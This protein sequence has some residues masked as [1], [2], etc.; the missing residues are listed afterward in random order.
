MATSTF[1]I[2]Q[3]KV[4]CCYFCCC[5]SATQLC[6][7]LCNSMNYSMPGLPIPHHPQSLP[8]FM[9]IALVMPSSH[10][11][12]WCP[13]LLLPSIFPKTRDFSDESS[14][15]IR[16][17]KYGSFNVSPSSD[18]SGLISL[19]IDWFDLLACQGTFRSLLQHHGSKT[20][21]LWHSAF[22]TVQLSN[23]VCPLGR[24]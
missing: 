21:V 10:L 18:Y 6:L 4:Y 15:H 8:K 23:S 1:K 19:K 12:L 5:C 7:T 13:L 11:I 3:N 16:W 20:S 9:S 2:F 24:P 17:P 14:V 22:S